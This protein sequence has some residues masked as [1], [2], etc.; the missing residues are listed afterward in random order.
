ML[1]SIER[2]KGVLGP[3]PLDP[4]LRSEEGEERTGGHPRSPAGKNPCTL[5]LPR[6]SVGLSSRTGRGLGY[7]SATGFIMMPAAIPPRLELDEVVAEDEIELPAE[8]HGG[9]HVGEDGSKAWHT[10]SLWADRPILKTRMTHV[11]SRGSYSLTTFPAWV[12]TSL[13]PIFEGSSPVI[14]ES[15]LR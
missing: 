2:C 13:S 5:L 15:A 9:G 1:F 3:H 12:K 10:I 14:L 4:P 8:R 11:K 7:L 6:F